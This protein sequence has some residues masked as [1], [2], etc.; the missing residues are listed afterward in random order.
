MIFKDM[1]PKEPNL[2]QLHATAPTH[3]KP[4]LPIHFSAPRTTSKINP[5]QNCPQNDSHFHES[6]TNPMMEAS[7]AHNF[8]YNSF[9]ARHTTLHNDQDETR[10]CYL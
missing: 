9:H 2:M 1:L 5:I 7:Q 8:N 10:N 4:R 6:K 3:E